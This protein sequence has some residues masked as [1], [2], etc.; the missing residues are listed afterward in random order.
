MVDGVTS[1]G[2][3]AMINIILTLICIAFSWWV[4]LNIRLDAWMRQADGIQAKALHVLLA[5]VFGHGLAT[6]LID[7]LGWS[8]M[9]G[10]LF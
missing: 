1:L 9:L 7:Y 5:I 4:I 8:K 3:T 10:Q 2:V 6:F